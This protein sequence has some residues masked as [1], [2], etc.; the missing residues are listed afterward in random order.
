MTPVMEIIEKLGER[1]GLK[2]AVGD[3]GYKGKAKIL[4]KINFG[5][6]TLYLDNLLFTE[7]DPAFRFTAA[8]EI[9]HWVLHRYNYRN[10]CFTTSDD[11]YDDEYSL[12]NSSERKPEQWLEFQANIFAASM[13]M[14][15]ETFAVALKRVQIALGIIR[16]IGR[17]YLSNADYSR[18]DFE[19]T[20]GGISQIFQA[21]KESVRVRI[22]ALHLLQDDQTNRF[23][24]FSSE[25]ASKLF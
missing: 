18:R 5:Q 19:A 23:T 13:V 25:S 16:N 2:F 17:V 21:S 20:V 6:E 22:K 9:G 24:I 14:P 4:G 10:W 3:L 1:T 11:L 15:R 12:K 7:M 8:H